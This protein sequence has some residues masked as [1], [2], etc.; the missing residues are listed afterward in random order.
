VAPFAGAT[1]NLC[2]R[3][4][5]NLDDQTAPLAKFW[6]FSSTH[7]AAHFTGIMLDDLSSEFDPFSPQFGEK[8]AIPNASYLVQGSLRNRSFPYLQRRV[9]LVQRLE[10]LNLGSQSSQPDR[11]RAHDDGGVYE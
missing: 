3:K 11:L 6:V 10:L 5:V 2:D 8:F 4:E 1:R 9:G 7:V